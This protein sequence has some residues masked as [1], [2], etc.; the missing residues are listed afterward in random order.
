MSC[1]QDRRPRCALNAVS[2]RATAT[3]SRGPRGGAGLKP[4]EHGRL[5]ALRAVVK[6]PTSERR[7]A[8]AEVRDEL[9]ELKALARRGATAGTGGICDH[10]RRDARQISGPREELLQLDVLQELNGEL[11]GAEKTYEEAVWRA[12][13]AGTTRGVEAANQ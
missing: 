6:P 8:V 11:Q 1:L 13:P 4:V 5:G 10:D 9:A 2:R 3:S 7:R 12:R